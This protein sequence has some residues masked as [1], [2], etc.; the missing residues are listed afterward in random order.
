MAWLLSFAVARLVPED[1]GGAM[2]Y[3]GTL[4]ELYRFF[5][6]GMLFYL[7]RDKLP[8]RVDL[9]VASAA[10]VALGALTPFFQE[11]CAVAGS[12]AVVALAYLWRP[13]HSSSDSDYSYG[14]YIYA[15]PAQQLVYHLTG[16]GWVL[17]I[18]LALPATVVLAAFSWHFV[19]KPAMRLSMFGR[20]SFGEVVSR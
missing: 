17:N 18:A 3:V 12:Y 5:G 7:Y 2:Y 15:F 16:S 6:A 11:I 9:A 19:E 4:A 10:I 20:P 1:A 13:L 14:V 8:I